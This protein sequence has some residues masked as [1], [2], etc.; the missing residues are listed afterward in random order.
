[1]QT[2]LSAKRFF[3][4][5]WLILH[6]WENGV[7][8]EKGPLKL[9][10]N[11]SKRKNIHGCHSAIRYFRAF[12]QV[13]RTT[14]KGSDFC[15]VGIIPNEFAFTSK[16]T[17]KQSCLLDNNDSIAY[18]HLCRL[19]TCLSD[20]FVSYFLKAGTLSFLLVWRKIASNFSPQ[21][22]ENSFWT[23]FVLNCW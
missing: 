18:K 12:C 7:G 5:N 3:Q 2:F 4:S 17:E 14:H 8:G 6:I 11:S 21:C 13:D 10:V 22:L 9:S 20:F 15:L 19:V 23:I 16:S 1:M